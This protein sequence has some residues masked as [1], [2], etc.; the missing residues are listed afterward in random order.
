MSENEDNNQP[1]KPVEV[2]V[3][4]DNEQTK[5]L[6]E[7]LRREEQARKLAEEQLEAAEERGEVFDEIRSKLIGKFKEINVKPPN[8]ESKADLDAASEQLVQL[9]HERKKPE[10]QG[11]DA[12]LSPEQYG[13]MKKQGEYPD[14]E[15]MVNDLRERMA[16]EGQGGEADRLLTMLLSR[17]LSLLKAHNQSCPEYD[18]EKT[19]PPVKRVNGLLLRDT[20]N[21]GD[22][23]DLKAQYRKRMKAKK[24]KGESA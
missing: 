6:M 7:Q 17:Q 15:S 5:I 13:I 19:K 23:F 4:V 14:V 22:V 8:I 20:D 3:S 12:P 24:E 10:I 9:Q 1:R 16:V 21:Y 2:K 18:P 11:G